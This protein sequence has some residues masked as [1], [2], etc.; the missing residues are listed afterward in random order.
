MSEYF[1]YAVGEKL[2]TVIGHPGRW[3]ITEFRAVNEV[4]SFA[5][6]RFTAVDFDSKKK[7]CIVT[8]VK[9]HDTMK[10]WIDEDGRWY[11]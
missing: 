2:R 5:K 9:Q 4:N 1:R 3:T 10:G 6:Y 11:N 7:K 8:G